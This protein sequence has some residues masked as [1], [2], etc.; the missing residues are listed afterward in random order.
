MVRAVTDCAAGDVALM[1]GAEPYT[2]A[3]PD[4]PDDRRST[5]A[6]CREELARE[7]VHLA[8][9]EP[10]HRAGLLHRQKIRGTVIDRNTEICFH[11]SSCLPKRDLV[12]STPTT[13]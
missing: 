6:A 5:R 1:I 12:T 10:Q 13:G 8:T 11:N 4:Q 2:A 9:A 7:L 3:S